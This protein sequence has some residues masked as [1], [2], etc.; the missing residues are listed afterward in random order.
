MEVL[1]YIKNLFF[2]EITTSILEKITNMLP[3]K[4]IALLIL[5]IYNL[6]DLVNSNDLKLLVLIGGLF[7]L[8]SLKYQKK[9]VYLKIIFF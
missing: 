1:I 4:T 7:S 3:T 5:D 2:T 8:F 6:T 9:L